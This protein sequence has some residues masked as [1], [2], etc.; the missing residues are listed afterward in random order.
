MNKSKA[1]SEIAVRLRR[2]DLVAASPDR[3]G[4]QGGYFMNFMKCPG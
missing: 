3:V 1:Q 2:S 4:P